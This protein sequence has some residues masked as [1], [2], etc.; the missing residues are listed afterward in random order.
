MTIRR[1]DFMS[2]AKAEALADRTDL[3]IISIT[4]P[5]STPALLALPEDRMLRLVFHDVDEPGIDDSVPDAP[6]T[7][8]SWVLF[9]LRHAKRLIRFVQNLD[10]AEYDF[11]LV[12]HC[13]A[14]ISRSAAVALYVA[15]ETGCLF[16]R[17]PLAG[18]ANS[19]VLRTL[20]LPSGLH[21]QRPR[22]LPKREQFLVGV[23]RDFEKELVR[24]VTTNLGT[25]EVTDLK[26][27]ILEVLDLA[28]AGIRR[29]AGFRHPPPAHQLRNW[30]ELEG[31]GGGGI[32]DT[33]L[34]GGRTTSDGVAW[35]DAGAT[36]VPPE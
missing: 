22:A 29:M 27:P 6:E 17:K 3:A 11:D 5:E 4:E 33:G 9:D 18:F 1:V 30:D 10:A 35:A 24:V 31:G 19:W 25:R 12:V 26:G 28:A 8:R 23:T 15:A 34:A 21:L 36:F 7:D 14:G 16:P 13:R 32:G 2:R 20:A